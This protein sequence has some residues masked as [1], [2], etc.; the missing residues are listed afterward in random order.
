LVAEQSPATIKR[1]MNDLRFFR[2]GIL[3]Y[4]KDFDAEYGKKVLD[5]L[6]NI[7]PKL[8]EHPQKQ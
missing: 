2:N 3:Y 4:G 5:F 6:N 8:K 7:Y 1:F